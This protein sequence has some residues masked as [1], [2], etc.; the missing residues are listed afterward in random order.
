MIVILITKTML[1]IPSKVGAIDEI[2]NACG[3]QLL[4]LFP[5]VNSKV[6]DYQILGSNPLINQHI[7][8]VWTFGFNRS[9]IPNSN[10][11]IK[12]CQGKSSISG[13]KKKFISFEKCCWFIIEWSIGLFS[14]IKKIFE[15][16][17]F[18]QH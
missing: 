17:C 3:W 7:F 9:F 10:V 11:W 1:D 4:L 6:V 5:K 18:P 12:I 2:R 16:F 15:S 8:I 14:P 13:A